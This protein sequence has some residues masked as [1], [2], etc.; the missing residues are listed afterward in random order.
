MSK[1]E[2]H[3]LPPLS[4]AG[5]QSYVDMTQGSLYQKYYVILSKVK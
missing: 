4:Y 2:N 5:P 3:Y 1:G